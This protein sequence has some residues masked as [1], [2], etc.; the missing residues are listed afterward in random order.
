MDE[1]IIK[2]EDVS[3]DI[4]A[5]SKYVFARTRIYLVWTVDK[6][7]YH[8]KYLIPYDLRKLDPHILKVMLSG[9]C[10]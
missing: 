7:G 3:D 2:C 5:P 8:H 4:I 10:E 1:I 9:M 6:L